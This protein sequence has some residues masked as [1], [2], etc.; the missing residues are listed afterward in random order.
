M[1]A[2]PE[3]IAAL[4]RL[5]ELMEAVLRDDVRRHGILA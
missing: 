5:E 2:K 3:D 1:S 4:G